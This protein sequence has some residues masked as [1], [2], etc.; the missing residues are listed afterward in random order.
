[1][2]EILSRKAFAELFGEVK[3][4]LDKQSWL[5]RHGKEFLMLGLRL[6]GFALGF[7][8]FAHHGGAYKIIGMIVIS[9][10][11]YG[12][13][14]TGTHEAGHRSWVSSITG[15]KIWGYFFSDFWTAQSSLWWHQRHVVIHHVFTNMPEKENAAKFYYPLMNKYVYFFVTPFLVNF[16]LVI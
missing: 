13:G 2:E 5:N 14:I 12:I 3:K 4:I 8:I 7:F 9:Y 1:M 10:F 11:F 15:N 16:W 6:L